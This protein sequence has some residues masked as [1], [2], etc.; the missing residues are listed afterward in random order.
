[1]PNRFLI[2]R[3]SA[4][5]LRHDEERPSRSERFHGSGAQTICLGSESLAAFGLVLASLCRS[6]AQLDGFG[7]I[8]VFIMLVVGGS[9]A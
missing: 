5:L 7:T 3:D 1:L 2:V 8:V 9:V 4:F 6:P